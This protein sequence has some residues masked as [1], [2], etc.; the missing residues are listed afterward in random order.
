MPQ[1]R[2]VEEPH[3]PSWELGFQKKKC[4]YFEHFGSDIQACELRDCTIS[5]RYH[6][7]DQ[8]DNLV[9]VW[10]L[11][12]KHGL[13]K[14]RN[15]RRHVHTCTH[16]HALRCAQSTCRNLD[17]TSVSSLI[18]VLCYSYVE[19]SWGKLEKGLQMC[20]YVASPIISIS[21]VFN[22]MSV[23]PSKT[24]HLMNFT[25]ITLGCILCM[26]GQVIDTQLMLEVRADAF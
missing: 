19:C 15:T 14:E 16:L 20:L 13:S 1:G 2:G 12:L 18:V 5:F 17:C 23:F 25:N 6:F 26:L 22:L 9:Y 3:S 8:V 21:K 7:S 24:S 11:W 4:S 10:T